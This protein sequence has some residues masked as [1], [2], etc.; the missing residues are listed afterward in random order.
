[1]LYSASAF[2]A[3]SSLGWPGALSVPPSLEVP[4][5]L[6]L[7]WAMSPSQGTPSRHEPEDASEVEDRVEWGLWVSRVQWS[8]HTSAAPAVEALRD[9]ARCCRAQ[10]DCAELCCALA[11]TRPGRLQAMASSVRKGS[12]K[13]HLDY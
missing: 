1:M 10:F 13:S 2:W 4:C 8:L 5:S 9:G 7:A 6:S 12:E 11:Q 3:Q